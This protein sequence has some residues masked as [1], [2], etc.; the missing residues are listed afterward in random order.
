MRFVIGFL[1]DWQDFDSIMRSPFRRCSWGIMV[2]EKFIGG[3]MNKPADN[4]EGPDDSQED[5]FCQ[6]LRTWRLSKC[7]ALY[8]NTRPTGR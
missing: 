1:E 3:K 5:F 2:K 4:S 6:S 8:D 7:L